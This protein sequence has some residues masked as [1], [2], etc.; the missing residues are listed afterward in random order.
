MV[1]ERSSICQADGTWTQSVRPTCLPVQC[2]TP[3]S[4]TNGKA[5]FTSV[6]YKS[7][8]SYQCG[9]GYMLSGNGTRTCEADQQWSGPEPSCVEINCPLPNGGILP[10]GWFE[11]SRTGLNAVIRFRCQPGMKMVGPSEKAVCGADGKWSSPPASCLAPCLVPLVEH[12]QTRER[13]GQVISHGEV[14]V[15]NCS[16]HYEL[17]VEGE[18][19]ECQNG[20]WSQQP[21]CVPARCKTMPIPPTNGMVVVPQTNHGSTALYQCKD[22]YS[23]SGDNTTSCIYGNWTG[24]TPSCQ[25]KYCSFPGYLTN[26]KILLV[27]NMGLY[28]YRPYVKKITNDRQILFDCEKGYKL[29]LGAPQGATCIDGEW[30]PREIP[31]CLPEYHPR[32]R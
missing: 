23:L 19:V 9:Q 20:S 16:Q 24:T 32:L 18:G 31:L 28:D 22:G 30:S 25:E 6:A 14:L 1:G 12:G 4:P 10:N 26:G 3:A 15:I 21:R 27:G 7:V 13:L 2:R 29:E 5:V 17:A 11:G 8:V